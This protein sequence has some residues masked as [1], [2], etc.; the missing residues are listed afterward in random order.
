MREV[1]GTARIGVEVVSRENLTTDV[2]GHNTYTVLN[3][4]DAGDCDT[5]TTE[6]EELFQ[7]RNYVSEREIVVYF[8]R[9]VFVDGLG[10]AGCAA[11]P[12]G[13]PGAA[14][15]QSASEW[16]LAHEVGHVLGLEHLMNEPCFSPPT[17]LMTSCGTDNIVD[18]A[19]I[20][21]YEID[22][23]RSSNLTRQC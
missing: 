23:M 6:Q 19:I 2:L 21:Q 11:H 15:A 13:K 4:L 1:Y 8:V 12:E 5:P 18:N 22:I 10:R 3:D 20:V 16:T 7:N 17:R 9:G 14:L